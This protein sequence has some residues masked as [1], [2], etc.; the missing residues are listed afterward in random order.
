MYFYTLSIIF[1]KLH[2]FAPHKKILLALNKTFTKGMMQTTGLG[3]QIDR[4]CAITKVWKF[5]STVEW[6]ENKLL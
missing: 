4:I 5:T 3:L 2:N 1:F 6:K